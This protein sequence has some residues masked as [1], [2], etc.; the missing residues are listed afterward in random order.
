[1]EQLNKVLTKC[2]G[3]K[4]LMFDSFKYNSFNKCFKQTLK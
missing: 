3:K 1:M 2:N 4:K